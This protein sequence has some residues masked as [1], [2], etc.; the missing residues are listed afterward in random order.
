MT[1]VMNFLNYVYSQ[2]NTLRMGATTQEHIYVH[3]VNAKLFSFYVFANIL[4]IC[5]SFQ[6]EQMATG[7][8]ALSWR[9]SALSRGAGLPIRDFTAWQLVEACDLQGSVRSVAPWLP[10]N[11]SLFSCQGSHTRYCSDEEHHDTKAF[12]PTAHRLTVE[13]WTLL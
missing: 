10:P 1:F 7:G 6:S 9:Q 2:Q 5:A 13:L 8:E 12:N 4:S 3:L 11:G